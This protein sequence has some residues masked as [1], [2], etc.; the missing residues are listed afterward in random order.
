M[1][2]RIRVHPG[3]SRENL[4]K[5]NESIYE[6]WIKEKAKDNKANL[7]LIKIL[8]KYFKSEASIKSGFTSRNKIVEIK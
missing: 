8:K 2:I 3:S 7:A 5:I 4:E 1:K 6:V